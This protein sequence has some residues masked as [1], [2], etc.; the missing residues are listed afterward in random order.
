MSLPLKKYEVFYADPPATY[1]NKN[2]GGSLVSGSAAKYPV[3]TLDE[4]M[5]LPVPEISEKNAVLFLWVTNPLLPEGLQI[6]KAW[7]FNYKTTIT[8]HKIMSLGLGFW[9]RGQVEFL[10]FGVRGKVKAFRMQEKNHITCGV[11]KHSE[12]PEQFRELIERATMRMPKKLELFAR[13][14]SHG[15]DVFG[16]EVN[17]SINLLKIE[18]SE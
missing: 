4:I 17:N 5:A 3:M 11:G 7:G 14:E 10:L 1:R 2:T 18:T 12:K 6:M 9:W 8:W 13:K 16:N 15:W